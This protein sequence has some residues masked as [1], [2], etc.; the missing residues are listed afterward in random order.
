[1]DSFNGEILIEL[2][3]ESPFEGNWPAPTVSRVINGTLRLQN[4]LG[5]PVP[6]N[7]AQHLAVVRRMVD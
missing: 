4:D 1:M 6:L 3:S 2:H 5:V 7:K